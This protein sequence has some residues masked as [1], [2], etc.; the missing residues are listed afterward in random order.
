YDVVPPGSGWSRD[1]FKPVVEGDKLY[2]RGAVDMKG[3]IA[4][5]LLASKVF[6]EAVKEFRGSI[7]IALVP[8]EEIGGVTGTGYMIETGISRPDYVIIAEPSGV[9]HLW[10]GHKG[11]LWGYI[12]VYGK[13]VHGST[14]W[15]GMNAFE[16]MAK[17]VLEFLNEYKPF[18]ESKVSKYDYGDPQGN[19][20]TITIGGEVKGGAKI[21]IVPGYY[22]FSIDRRI[23]VEE[24]IEE[25]EKEL[26]EF[27]DRLRKRFPEVRIEFKIFS[28]LSPAF[29]DPKS[30]LVQIAI[31]SIEEVYGKKPKPIIC[32]GGLDLH[33]YTDKGIETISYGP[34]PEERAHMA[35]EY[36]HISEVLNVAKAYVRILSKVL[37]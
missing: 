18:I 8:D 6:L 9:E 37:L 27:I 35:D 19:K 21:N 10:I 34:G 13:Q 22:A 1:P 12:E 36:V 2:G 32:I 29:T 23:I 26:N 33:Y 11:A 20:P 16:Y 14:P 7:E 15:L 31:E 24:S 17:I 28:K 4:A 30:R 25:V 5:F 3:G